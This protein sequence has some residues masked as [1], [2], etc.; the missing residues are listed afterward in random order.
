MYA[1][2]GNEESQH[3]RRED[4]DDKIEEGLRGYAPK[5]IASVETRTGDVATKLEAMSSKRDSMGRCKCLTTITVSES[6]SATRKS[7]IVLDLISEGDY[8]VWTEVWPILKSMGVNI[9]LA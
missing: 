5:A 4:S 6:Q 2:K 9:V 8:L 3:P 1:T 7:Q